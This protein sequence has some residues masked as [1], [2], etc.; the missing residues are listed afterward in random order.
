MSGPDPATARGGSS[1]LWRLLALAAAVAILFLLAYAFF[2]VPCWGLLPVTAVAAWPI[3]YHQRDVVLFERR[4]VLEGVTLADGWVRRRFW[5]GRLTQVLQVFVALVWATVLLA[6]ATLLGAEQWAV[7]AADALFLSLIIDPVQ[8]R[9]ARQVQAG[10]VGVFSRRWPLFALNLAFLTLAFL[11]VDFFLAGAPDTRGLPWHAVAEQAFARQ[12][13]AATCP[14]AGWLAGVLATVEGLAWHASQ[15]VIPSLPDPALKLA[16]WG[17][18]LAQAGLVAYLY[19]RLQLGV[20]AMFERTAGTAGGRGD[21]TFSLAFFYTILFLAVPY[22]YAALK[23]A[24]LDPQA[25]QAGAQR[26]VAW[27][28]PCETDPAVRDRLLTALGDDLART[29]AEVQAKADRRVDTA[30]DALFADVEQGVDRYLDWYFT[31]IGEYERLA[32]SVV[33]DFGTL[34]SEQLERHLFGDTGFADRLAAASDAIEADSTGAMAA[35]AGRLG[36]RAAAEVAAE[37]CRLDGVS[38]HALGDLERDR[39]RAA[40]ATTGGAAAGVV[41]A[42]LLAKNA[43]AMVAGKV[44]AKKGFKLAAGM[45]G[46]VAAKKGGSILLSATAATALCAPTGPM[47]VLCGVVAGTV[48]WLTIDKAMVEIDEALFRDEMRAE[49][50]ETV[51]EQRAALAEALKA[52][53]AA[54]IDAQALQIHNRLEGAFV[55]ARDGM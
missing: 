20:V 45:A 27:A 46:K 22:L 50:L 25:L 34:M 44:A 4:V 7:L 35:A 14:I 40:M 5:A 3:W 28:N 41:T 49:L 30:L 16:A 8:R 54:A 10:K 33:G 32:A 51:A 53:H 11:A 48:T 9:V 52:Q 26:V 43:G 55:P 6:L 19:T 42:K 2:A 29:R 39:M 47:A 1:P 38:L 36:E 21:G 15:L 18:A 37:P 13:E 23:L 12:A 17:A 24:D 31:V